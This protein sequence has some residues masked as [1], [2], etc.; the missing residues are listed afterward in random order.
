MKKVFLLLITLLFL[1][2]C[3]NKEESNVVSC[4]DFYKNKYKV[5]FYSDD[6]LL[7]E[8]EV[9]QICDNNET[10][11]LPVPVKKGYEFAGWYYDELF[12]SKADV[13]NINEVEPNI[14]RDINGCDSS[15]NDVNLYALWIE[16]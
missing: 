6:K 2:S 7:S 1:C 11:E 15:Y 14:K 9:C 5:V 16:K 3:S 13:Q 12:L 10:S 8:L 4:P